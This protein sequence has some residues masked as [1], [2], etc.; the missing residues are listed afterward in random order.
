MKRL[1][2]FLI[3]IITLCLNSYGNGVNQQNEKSPN[4]HT[5]NIGVRAG[6]N[7]SMFLVSK[8]KIQ[9]VTIED[10]QNNYQLGYF[11]SLFMRFNMKRHYL[12]PEIAYNISKSEISFDKLGAQHPDIEPD[13]A[14]LRSTIYS[15]DI[16][17]LYGY[18]IVKNGPY[19]LALFAGPKF[20][21]IWQKKNHITFD[22][23]DLKDI[24]EEL[25]PI[26]FSITVGVVINISR[27]FFDFRYEQNV[28]NISKSVTYESTTSDGG[29][30]TNFI[31]LNRREQALSFSLGLFF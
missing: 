11:G 7:S 30:K 18:H 8:F 16:P 31:K 29:S 24:S 21:Y 17:L 20:R 28:H 26:N 6:F 27:V 13:Y 1:G 14:T 19:G 12:Q 4:W 25:Y 10:F 15:F 5:F 23:F 3:S 2:L 9:D 22:N